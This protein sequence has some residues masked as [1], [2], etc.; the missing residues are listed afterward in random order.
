MKSGSDNYRASSIQGI[1]KRIKA[2]GIKVIIYEPE[3]KEAEFF[4]SKVIS[5]LD[6]FKKQSDLIVANRLSEDISD[7]K[8]KIYTRDLF[9]GD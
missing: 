6:K 3:V 7:V 1:M 9:N 2:K 5:D 4:N 8:N